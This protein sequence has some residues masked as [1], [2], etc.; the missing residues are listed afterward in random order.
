MT[1]AIPPVLVGISSAILA[2]DIPMPSSDQIMRDGVAVGV[3][4]ISLIWILVWTLPK[5]NKENNKTVERICDSFEKRLAAMA[6]EAHEDREH[7]AEVLDSL[8]TNCAA[9]RAM[10]E[11]C[12]E[13]RKK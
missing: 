10:K 5:I 1:H 12:V 2:L 9:A 4:G 8:Q 7:L 13:F 3:L 11:P 6:V